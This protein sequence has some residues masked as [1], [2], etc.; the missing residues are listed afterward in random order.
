M[1]RRVN[2]PP[3]EDA[4]PAPAKVSALA[5]AHR[6][7]ARHHRE[8]RIREAKAKY[9][10]I[11]RRYP[12]NAAAVH[13]LGVIAHQEGQPDLAVDL[14]SKSI[15]ENRTIPVFHGHLGELYRTL[16]RFD[17]A[18][19]CC[20]RALEL[21]AVYPDALNTLGAALYAKGELDAAQESLE[22]AVTFQPDFAEAHANLGNIHRAQKKMEAAGESYRR[23]RALQP[24]NVA[25]LIN[26]GNVLASLG[27][28]EEA[29]ASY[30]QAVRLKPDLAAAHANLAMA[31]FV[32]GKALGDQGKWAP[33]ADR[34][35][36]ALDHKA[37]FLEA[38]NN[39]GTCLLGQGKYEQGQAVFRRL[40]EQRRGRIWQNADA[41]LADEPDE[42]EASPEALRTTRF[43]LVDRVEQVE[44]LLA[45]GLI[46]PSFEKMVA[47]YR[48]V[49]DELGGQQGADG[50]ITLSGE[51]TRRIESFY[52][53]VIHYADAPRVPS[54]AVNDALDF[55][56]I[57]DAYLSTPTPVVYFD[58]FL[59]QEALS[60]L[61]RF[62]LDSTIYFR[63]DP[64]GFVWSYIN[65][66]FNC[67]LLYQIAEELKQRLPRVI[68]GQFLSNMWIY[69]YQN[70][71]EGVA[72][73]TDNAAVTFNFWLTPDTANLA[74]G[75]SGLVVY[76]KEQPLDWDWME[77]NT[78]KNLPDTQERI[79]EFLGS[80]ETVTI[81]Y[82]DNRAVLFHSNLFHRSDAFHFEE[83]FENRR[84][85]VAMVFG[86]RGGPRA[87]S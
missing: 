66:G 36:Q 64:G 13:V 81:P 18:I 85:N 42:R 52:D 7:A 43:K 69:R 2:I 5:Q 10:E 3:P 9:R 53:K 25:I 80:A 28:H 75:Q 29:V 14:M 72:A 55:E 50:S 54:G 87:S 32:Q 77:Y 76:K 17:E 37:D 44:Y 15:A 45:R 38:R 23:A 61:R 71:G 62:C 63:C 57:E 30:R 51:Q 59:S 78:N 74:P 58:D 27:R 39:L 48:S 67:S 86:F 22:Q 79:K 34:Y 70:H 26:L 83:G 19:A 35:R 68:G 46:D 47:R 65:D 8:G 73:H 4:R 6:A 20:R 41:L 31:L 56:K 49:L 33:A 84:M 11:L 82:R 12:R 40:M 16:G 1:V 24:N 21:R 60:R